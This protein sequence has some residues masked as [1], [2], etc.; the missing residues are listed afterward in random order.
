LNGV[1]PL[2]IDIQDTNDTIVKTISSDTEKVESGTGTGCGRILWKPTGTGT[3]WGLV[4]IPSIYV[5]QKMLCRFTANANF[6]QADS[7]VAAT[8]T[9]Q[10]GPGLEHSD[11]S[12]TV[13]NTLTGSAG[14]YFY[15][16]DEND[17]GLAI[18]DSEDDWVCIDMECP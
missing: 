10:Y 4:L 13:H 17:A 16:G 8:I 3:Q 11:T 15:K 5:P 2:Q 14:V 9:D 12:I 1:V 18:W 6:T 7:S